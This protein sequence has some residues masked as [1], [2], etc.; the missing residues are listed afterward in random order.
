M[1]VAKD[2]Y[3]YWVHDAGLAS[4]VDVKTGKETWDER[5]N[6]R[7]L[8]AS[9][10]LTGDRITAISEDGRVVV[11]RANPEKFQ[12]VWE[13][14]LDEPVYATPAVADGKMFLRTARHLICVGGK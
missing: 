5:L 6:M 12:K 13:T 3:L 11:F 9:L 4:C 1:P 14:S 2:G 8:F 7:T 10:V